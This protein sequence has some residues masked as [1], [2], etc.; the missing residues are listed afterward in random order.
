MNLKTSNAPHSKGLKYM[1]CYTCGA[2][3]WFKEICNERNRSLVN[4]NVNVSL[5]EFC[6][7]F[8]ENVRI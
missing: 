3:K 6:K 8:S 5:D 1:K 4:I 2:F 7:N